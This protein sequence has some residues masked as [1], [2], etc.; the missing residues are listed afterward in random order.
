MVIN[1]RELFLRSMLVYLLSEE[2]GTIVD[3]LDE[4]VNSR[5]DPGV[6]R[7]HPIRRLVNAFHNP[8]DYLLTEVQ[9]DP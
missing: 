2:S 3:R 8:F 5:Y 6:D 1:L 9:H 7:R 4:L